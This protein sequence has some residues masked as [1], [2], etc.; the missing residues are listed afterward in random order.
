MASQV[1]NH[2]SKAL[3]DCQYS[4]RTPTYIGSAALFQDHTGL[5]P[6]GYLHLIAMTRLPGVPVVDVLGTLTGDDRKIIK[7][8]LAKILEYVF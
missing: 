5:F 4:G 3:R 1:F 8:E 6:G 7:T 2:E